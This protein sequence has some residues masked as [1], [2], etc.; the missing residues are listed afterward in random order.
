ML[1]EATQFCDALSQF[2]VDVTVV[3]SADSQLNPLGAT[4]SAFSSLSLGPPLILVCLTRE[5]R[6]T[7]AICIRKAFAVHL[8]HTAQGNV[9]RCF[10]ADIVDKFAGLAYGFNTAGIPCLDEA[11]LCLGAP[12][13]P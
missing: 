3:N 1:V 7:K 6:T 11:G 10:A 4:V 12:C 5:S 8:L 2:P 9:A 13:T